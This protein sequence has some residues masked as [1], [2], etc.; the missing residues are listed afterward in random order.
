MPV[1]LGSIH[2][3]ERIRKTEPKVRLVNRLVKGF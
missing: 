1:L 3:I 2:F